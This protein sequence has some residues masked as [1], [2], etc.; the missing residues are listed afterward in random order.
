MSD[1]ALRTVGLGK[2]YHIGAEREKYRT[3]RDT[4]VQAA[5]RPFERIRHPGAATHSSDILWALRNVDLE[6]RQGDALG[7]VGRNGAGKS[8]L[9]KVLSHITEPTEGRVEVKGRVGS[10]LE[11]G[12]GF[13]A[14]LT[15]RENIQLNAAI[16]GMSRAQTRDKFDDIVEFA[17]IG[18][19]LDTPVKRYS[20]GMYVRLA[21]AVAAYLEPDILMVD[22]VL[23]VGDAGFQRK[24]LGKMEDVAGGGRTVL[25]VSHNMQAIRR[26]C[27]TAVQIEGGRVVN[28]GEAGSV[29][30]KYLSQQAE[31]GASVTW[32]PGEGPGD[33]EARLVC[34]EVLDVDG[35]VTNL[36][37]TDKPFTVRFEFDLSRV[38]RALCVGFD[39]ASSD[40]TVVMRSY[41]TD[42][43]EAQWPALGIGRNS[44]GCTVPAGLL[45]DGR[46]FVMPRISLHWVRWIVNGDSVVAFEVHRDSGQS[47]L[48]GPRPGMIAPV[49]TW[50]RV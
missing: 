35:D 25:F 36:I 9:L 50:Q 15:G 17:E 30:A 23:A 20:S 21:F 31:M 37:S 14:E 26:L 47:P 27:E 19:F 34:V 42:G 32:G 5:K 40:G 49:L 13:H 28:S 38:D 46:Y 45:N 41:Q 7:I 22:E 4:I 18:Q 10:L 24:C 3:L 39:L 6:L 29:V 11:V 43:A 2:M 1:V 33:D 48:L 44:I 16:L 12:T 8:T